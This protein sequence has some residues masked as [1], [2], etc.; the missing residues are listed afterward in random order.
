MLNLRTMS[1]ILAKELVTLLRSWKAFL[2]LLLL[3][4]LT[5]GIFW[6]FWLNQAEH[7]SIA[8]RARFSRQMFTLISMVHLCVMGIISPIMT[9]TAFTSERESRTLDLLYTTT[10]S[11]LH[12]LLGKWF[13]AIAWQLALVVGVLPILAL[14]FQLGGVGSDEYIIIIILISTTVA[15]YSM[16]AL[17]VSVWTRRSV[18]AMFISLALVVFLA[19]LFTLGIAVLGEILQF[20]G[21]GNMRASRNGT[22]LNFLVYPVS[23][24]TTYFYYLDKG[25]LAQGAGLSM[26]LTQPH[27]IA[28][29][30]IQASIFSLSLLA[31]WKGL[32]RGETVKL[33]K[34]KQI[35]DDPEALRKRRANFPF[36]L[37]DP[38]RRAQAITDAQQPM[39]VKETRVG[40]LNRFAMLIRLSYIGVALS[41]FTA[42]P[43][44]FQNDDK[45]A[46]YI[47][48]F[49]AVGFMLAFAPILSATSL[50]KEREEDTLN[51]LVCSPLTLKQIIWAKYLTSLKLMLIIAASTM[52]LPVLIY[53]IPNSLGRALEIMLRLIPYIV[54]VAAL[55]AAVGILCSALCRRSTTAIVL[56]YFMMGLMLFSPVLL[57]II[58][59]MLHLNNNIYAEP[60]PVQSIHFVLYYLTPFLSPLSSL[61]KGLVERRNP[62]EFIGINWS[63]FY[64]LVQSAGMLLL[65]KW[66]LIKT[67]SRLAKSLE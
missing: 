23:P 29:M 5:G 67:E 59:E 3:L 61:E 63:F 42:F 40:T 49:T 57:L 31:G 22:L 17:A 18:T 30:L 32:V 52:L 64:I 60:A 34:P 53:F 44:A 26:Y 13:S 50:C 65:S 54:S 47:I 35:I 56:G 12:L 10:L 4:L 66:I 38:L 46:M 1:P 37:I 43:A 39:M 33:I 24:V 62:S 9:A 11:R 25:Y 8:E 28:H 48:G 16:M 41:V 6:G 55:Y 45:E 15:T 14:S 58:A 7:I 27:F 2:F 21:L 20:Y 19:G 51:L 36:Y